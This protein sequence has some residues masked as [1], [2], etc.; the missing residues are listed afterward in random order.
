MGKSV[1]ELFAQLDEKPVASASV[2]QVHVGY[3]H[4]KL[5][6][7]D[8]EDSM[9]GADDIYHAAI[10]DGG[11]TPDGDADAH[12]LKVVLKLQHRGI[13]PLMRRDM[14]ACLRLTRF[15]RWL[16][17]EFGAMYMVLEAWQYEMYREFDFAHEAANLREVRANLRAAGIDAIVPMPVPGMVSR[18]AFAMNFCDGF[19]VTDEEALAMHAVDREALMVRIVQIYAQ[20]LFV[21]GLFNADPHAGNLMVHVRDGRA[22]PVLLDFGM[23]VRLEPVQRL[24][25][26]Q[27]AFAAQQMDIQRLQEAIAALGVKNNQSD[28]DPS[29][30]LDFWRFFLRDTGGRQESTKQAKDFFARKGDER[31]ADKDAGVE[32]RRVEALP[33][34]FIFFWRV[35]GLLRGLCATLQVQVPYMDMLA[36]RAKVALAMQT[37]APMRA[38]SYAPPVT[39]LPAAMTSLHHR[40]AELLMSVCVDGSV[41]AGVQVCVQRASAT[42]AEACAGFRGAVDP[43]AMLVDT[44]MPLLELSAIPPAL[45]VHQLVAAGRAAYAQPLRD[46][47]PGCTAA[48]RAG[49]TIGDALGHLVPLDGTMQWRTPATKLA[50]LTQQLTALSAAPLRSDDGTVDASA[51]PKD[52]RSSGGVYATLLA[53]IVQGVCGG[54]PYPAAVRQRL[55]DPLGIGTSVHVGPV[56]P[57]VQMEAAQ[58]STGFG[59]Q[60]QRFAAMGSGP[61]VPPPPPAADAASAEADPEAAA[62]EEAEAAKAEKVKAGVAGAAS[63][64][65]HEVPLNAGIVNSVITQSGCVPGLGAFATARGVCALLGAAA[66]GETGPLRA[67]NDDVGVEESAMYGE[68]AWVRGLQKYA[69]SGGTEAHVLGLHSFGGSFAFLC[70]RSGVSVAIL[71]NDGQLDYSVTRRILDVV[72]DELGMGQVDFLSAGLF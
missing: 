47:W 29:R 35:I 19:K 4:R 13:E 5:A 26:A 23:T 72:S 38:L 48:A 68:R 22:L 7:A 53:G 27:L 41:A 30:D 33:S 31:K 37:P 21:D 58:L 25:Y 65:A 59:A 20:Q 42:L 15:A 9:D 8:G 10:A 64:F 71:L 18:R 11:P 69:C 49:Y 2:A 57:A 14:I 16:S 46:E 1:G 6:H 66:R 63:R 43:R 52:P 12:G 24:G 44:P 56:P 32:S 3:L 51:R 28:S 50:D 34:S 40:L 67:L 61:E 60:L 39:P 54:Q 62:A 55:L 36:A 45:A 17:P 70:P